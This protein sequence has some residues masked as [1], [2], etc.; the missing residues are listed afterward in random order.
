MKVHK[1]TLT[2]MQLA[3]Q[4]NDSILEA[5]IE[6]KIKG[7]EYDEGMR[8]A[9]KEIAVHCG[10]SFPAKEG[11]LT[12]P[13]LVGELINKKPDV[14]MLNDTIAK[15][16]LEI[17]KLH[18]QIKA[19]EIE[20]EIHHNALSDEDLE[21][22]SSAKW[23]NGDACIYKNMHCLVVGWLPSAPMIV[24]ENNNMEIFSVMLDD[25]TKPETAEQKAARKRVKNAEKLFYIIKKNITNVGEWADCSEEIK[26]C[27]FNFIDAGLLQN[28]KK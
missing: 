20:I 6:A 19:Q 22:L 5:V 13:K 21:N 14:T 25:I 16:A 8:K 2:P 10:T 7:D 24:I 18:E 11:Y 27:Y 4:L 26:Q 17:L 12:L 28:E 1:I 23:K 15:Q 3:Q 9:M